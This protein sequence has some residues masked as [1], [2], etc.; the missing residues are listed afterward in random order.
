MK[1]SQAQNATVLAGDWYT[2]AETI[3]K[4]NKS[5]STID[6]LVGAGELKSKTEPRPGRKPERLYSAEDVE[7]LAIRVQEP[8]RALRVIRPPAQSQLAIPP[9][10]ITA[11]RDV[12]KDLRKPRLWLTLEEAEDYSGI[13]RAMLLELCKTTRL[14]AFKWRGWKI[15]RESLEAF[16]G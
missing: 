16:E 4:L 3:G 10:A 1:K 11:L 2:L 7:K 5:Q 9:D 6:R 8:S 14:N 15:R 13:P 12:M